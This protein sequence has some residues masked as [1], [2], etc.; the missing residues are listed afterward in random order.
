MKTE[1][2]EHIL[3][4]LRPK[5]AIYGVVLEQINIEKIIIPKNLRI[6]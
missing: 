6:Y 5:Y 4:I 1:T 2:T 3:E